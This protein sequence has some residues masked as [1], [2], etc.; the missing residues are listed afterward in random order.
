MSV[1]QARMRT[2]RWHD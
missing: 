1:P 2:R